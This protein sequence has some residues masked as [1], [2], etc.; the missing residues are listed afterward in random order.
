MAHRLE[1]RK[2]LIIFA[3][4]K[5]KLSLPDGRQGLTD[6][7]NE[8]HLPTFPQEKKEQARFPRK[9]GNCQWPQGIGFT[10][11]KRQKETYRF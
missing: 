5:K 4:L 8:T 3:A 2:I 9:N 1:I 7:N 6:N 10:Q 11:E